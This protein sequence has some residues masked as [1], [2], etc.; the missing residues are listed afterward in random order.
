MSS[1]SPSR[2][3][4]LRRSSSGGLPVVALFVSCAAL[5]CDGAEVRDGAQEEGTSPTPSA[6]YDFIVS[7]LNFYFPEGLASADEEAPNPCG[8][9]AN[10]DNTLYEPLALEGLEVDGF[11]LDGEDSQG[12][13]LCEHTD[14]VSPDGGSGIDFAFI[15]VIDMIRPA[16]PG[17]TIEVVL[18]SAPSQGLVK[19][20]IRVSGVD[21]LTNDDEV[22]VLVM[23]TRDTPLLGTDGEIIAGCSVA[24]DEDPTFQTRFNGRIEDGV[25]LAGPADIAVGKV[26]LL[27]I[28]DR[29]ISLK[30]TML[31]ATVTERPDGL[32]DV[33]GLL[34]GWWVRDEM[35]EAIGHA[36]LTI[37]ANKG[38]L[39]CVLDNHMDHAMDGV[40]CDAMSMIFRVKA[41]SGFITGLDGE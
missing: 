33:D 22:D 41:V 6:T 24:S 34:A 3:M 23:T 14:F 27:V 4:R 21:D 12:S 2:M 15:H 17:Q 1:P 5:A 28:Q 37:G 11:D 38:E 20:G 39:E 36:V 9:D 13:G 16:R 19:I 7:E 8:L 10:T 25:L 40:T 32:F 18:A 26:D 30:G 31:R 29:V 35:L